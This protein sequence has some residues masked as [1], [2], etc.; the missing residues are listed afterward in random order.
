MNSQPIHLKN[1][2]SSHSVTP[3]NT[4]S[5]ERAL[6]T[7]E[8]N[9]ETAQVELTPESTKTNVPSEETTSPPSSQQHPV[10]R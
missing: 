7:T 9:R 10:F 8:E 2:N 1:Q 6:Q 4:Q 3:F 5:E